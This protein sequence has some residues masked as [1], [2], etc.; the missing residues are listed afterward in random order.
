MSECDEDAV[1]REEIEIPSGGRFILTE[2]GESR[3]QR[4]PKDVPAITARKDMDEHTALA[5]GIAEYMLEINGSHMGR[6]MRV[7]RVAVDY[8]DRAT[9]GDPVFPA[10]GVYATGPGTFSD[11]GHVVTSSRDMVSPGV[12]VPAIDWYSETLRVDVE[13]QD[14]EQ[15]IG[16][17]M[18]LTTAF[19][20]ADWFAGFRRVLPYYHNT[21]GNYSLLTASHDDTPDL[22]DQNIR[23][24]SF[25]FQADIQTYEVRRL[26]QL[27]QVRTPGTPA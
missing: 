26:P 20:P 16:V 27:V 2:P 19:R 18:M 5:Y 9:T 4:T 12:F 25:T 23:L 22:V 6:P 14:L 8:P 11:L 3:P 24:L 17:R 15:R 13:C 1:E 10:A 7:A 21:L